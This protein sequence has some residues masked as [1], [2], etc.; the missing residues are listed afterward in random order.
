MGT[1][2]FGA[3]RNEG[4]AR[5]LFAALFALALAVRIVIPSGFMPVETARG[6]VVGICDGMSSGTAIVI[7]LQ[8]SDRGEH[9]SNDHGQPAPCVFAGLSA[10]TLAGDV[11]PALAQPALLWREVV[12]P[13]PQPSAPVR[14]A[15][16]TPPLRGPPAL[17]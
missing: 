13:P 9:R 14:A 4:R 2:M 10:P 11:P 8:R 15:F 17:A 7:D 3:I 6:M 5:S 12:L 16:R 1:D